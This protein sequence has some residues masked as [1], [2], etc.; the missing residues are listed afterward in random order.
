[1]AS[2]P[3]KFAT[4][5]LAS[6]RV[7]LTPREI[8]CLTL[9]AEGKSSKE[10]AAVLSIHWKTVTTHIDNAKL[11]LGVETRIAAVVTAMRAGLIA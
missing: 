10:I 2:G 8:E 1:M 11:K 3:G 7:R 6:Q 9:L 5:Q 4:L